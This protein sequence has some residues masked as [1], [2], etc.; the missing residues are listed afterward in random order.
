MLQ[1]ENLYHQKM[2]NTARFLNSH[3]FKALPQQ[4]PIIVDIVHKNRFNN[5]DGGAASISRMELRV[6]D[7][8]FNETK[9][10]AIMDFEKHY[11]YS[12]LRE[13]EREQS[14]S[15]EEIR[16]S[17]RHKAYDMAELL[18]KEEI[19]KLGGYHH[20]HH[21]VNHHHQQRKVV[22]SP[23]IK[24][25]PPSNKNSTAKLRNQSSNTNL[26]V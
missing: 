12:P 25:S 21:H 17:L 20:T 3:V 16:E 13:A 18:V 5:N 23:P 26:A 4:S 24:M 9:E 1:Y 7:G 6:F 22:I 8:N 11:G 15:P 14:K 10:Q 19:R 2:K